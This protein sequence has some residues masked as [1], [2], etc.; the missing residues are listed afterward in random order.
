MRDR[1][2]EIS[3][4]RTRIKPKVLGGFI[5]ILSL[6]AVAVYI[7]FTSFLD[8][9]RTRASLSQPNQKLVLLNSTLTDIYEAESN[10]RAYTLTND[11][12]YLNQYFSF[13]VSI[14][15]KVDTL[16]VLSS[17]NKSQYEK[18][19][20]TKALLNKKGTIL[21]GLIDL[22]KSD[23]ESEFFDKALHEISK[24]NID[25]L[26]PALVVTQK[27]VTTTSQRDTLVGLN[28]STSGGFFTRIKH[29]LSGSQM[30]D[31]T[32]TRVNIQEVTLV[33]TLVAPTALADTTLKGILSMLEK[34]KTEQ[35][36]YKME[37]SLKELELLRSDK[38]IMDEIRSIV[39][40]LEHEELMLTEQRRVEAEETLRE[41]LT[42]L[43][44]LGGFALFMILMFVLM[45][46]RDLSKSNYYRNQ[47]I[48][49]KNYAERLLSIKEQFLATMSHEIRTPLSA[50]IGFARQLGRSGLSDKQ[51][52]L[53]KPVESSSEH[54]LHIVNDIL[55]FS[56]MEAGKLTLESIPFNAFEVLQESVSTLRIKAL[57]KKIGLELNASQ[58][59]CTTLIG[60]PF[61]LKQILLNLIGNA[62]KF[63]DNGYVQ[64]YAALAIQSSMD[65]EKVELIVQVN[66]T[67][68]GIS[69]SELDAIFDDFTQADSGIARRFGGTGL[70]LAI[71]KRLV[72]MQNGRIEVESKLNA[73]TSFNVSIPF[74]TSL[75]EH[76]VA[77]AQTDLP[78]GVPSALKIVIVDDDEMNR[79]LVTET[80]KALGINPLAF[81]DPFSTLEHLFQY[82]CDIVLSD[83]QMP[84]MSGSELV[85]RLRKQPG[86]NQNVPVI[87]I[88]ANVLVSAKDLGFNGLLIKPFDEVKLSRV[89]REC[90][91]GDTQRDK[92]RTVLVKSKEL[93]PSGSKKLYDLSEIVR[94]SG[95]DSDAT[96]LIV[97]TFIKNTQD[98]LLQLSSSISS[99][100]F[101]SASAIAH[102]MKPTFKQFGIDR[103]A[104]LLLL[105]EESTH[106]GAKPNVSSVKKAFA[107]LAEAW[108]AVKSA[109]EKEL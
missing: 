59:V 65:S 6:A 56:K 61:R 98:N 83:L 42:K 77:P 97:S 21:D 96:K 11:E 19:T 101:T 63:T 109:M 46:F 7:T 93:K 71:V 84:G 72:D 94:F 28:G 108:P 18:V 82:Q 4:F 24:A 88:T 29:W 105:I 14:S 33:D 64:V 75:G 106:N 70:G 51:Q 30:A 32:V 26:A 76:K 86:P 20:Q 37:V 13:L 68:I 45:I 54:L 78:L 100:N 85:S 16:I 58:E 23:K 2:R 69:E 107:E 25:S 103:C 55:D 3:S 80:V 41:S 40:L 36:A 12:D 81:P 31:T 67:G 87:A 8:I 15:E 95:S 44:I 57:E 9:S 38:V 22:K 90:L 17:P 102:R 79:I 66:D 92:K 35:V 49:A 34:I 104:E 74:L 10:A 52:E 73:G 53:L 62:I 27:R 43:L 89:L 47:L 99:S 60:D 50:I 48:A 91:Y 1:I 39:S 5:L